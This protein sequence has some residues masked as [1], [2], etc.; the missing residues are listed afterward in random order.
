MARHRLDLLPLLDVFMVVLFVFATIQ[1]QRLGDSTRDA[2]QLQRQLQV[3]GQR[4]RVDGVNHLQALGADGL[5][6]IVVRAG[7]EIP[8]ALVGF[9]AAVTGGVGRALQV[10]LVTVGEELF[11]GRHDIAGAGVRR[12]L[13]GRRSGRCLRGRGCSSSCLLLLGGST[14]ARAASAIDSRPGKT[15]GEGGPFPAREACGFPASPTLRR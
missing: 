5:A 12:G 2:E 7:V 13:G 14:M 8:A 9:L 3:G 1:E 11:E 6:L 10:Q 4:R 15:L